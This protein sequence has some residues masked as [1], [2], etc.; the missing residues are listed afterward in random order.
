MESFDN[1]G[2]RSDRY[3]SIC[4][5]KVK[6]SGGG[7]TIYSVIM[8]KNLFIHSYEEIISVE[9]LLDA[10]C[11][12]RRGKRVRADVLEFERQLM[13]NILSLHRDLAD[14]TYEHS[15]YEA[16]TIS[17]PKTRNIHKATVADRVLH[18]ALYRKLYP[19]FDSKFISDSFSCR[20]NKGVHKGLNR[21]NDYGRKE[22]LNH[23]KTV[24]ILKCDV[25]KFFAT[26]DQRV[27]LQIVER[28][29]ADQRVKWLLEKIVGSFY[30]E[31]DGVGLPLG[32]LTSQL[33]A[34]VYMNDFD[35]FVKHSLGVKRYIRYAD[36][37]VLLSRDK[38]YLEK[39]LPKMKEY[40]K[41][42]LQLELHPQK[43]ELK[44]FASGVDFLGWVHF[45]DH[46]VLRTATK[47][48]M[49]R[50][51][52]QNPNGATFN[53]YKGLLSHGNTQGLLQVIVKALS[54]NW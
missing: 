31:R 24:W 25:R 41:E 36:D 1:I 21:F 28:S 5:V 15:S 16:F 9:N 30:S 6:A 20:V 49:I 34:N 18:R 10:W 7:N 48:K 46:R 44:T 22:S 14:L 4:G 40:L 32:N 35:Q 23:H 3:L 19:F 12:F 54:G 33:F 29:I 27:L 39:L 37:F 11:E 2:T 38:A 43:I 26:I 13:T 51:L 45:P 52:N 8:G 53:S 50:V 47:R 42:R 17:D